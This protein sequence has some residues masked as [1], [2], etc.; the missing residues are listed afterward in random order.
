MTK[1]TNARQYLPKQR[2]LILITMWLFALMAIIFIDKP[3]SIYINQ[4]GWDKWL[5]LRNITEKLPAVMLIITILV[6]AYKNLGKNNRYL[7]AI[8]GGIYFYLMISLAEVIKNL[9]KITFGRYWPKTWFDSNF[10]LIEHGVYGFNW[11]NGFN[12]HSAFPSGHSTYI[13]F[14]CIWLILLLPK[15]NLLWLLLILI[16]P[17]CLIILNYHFL[18]DCLAGVG[19][20][21]I[22]GLI[23]YFWWQKIQLKFKFLS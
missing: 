2:M 16:M 21:Y 14:C 18:G 6:V 19:L 3:L 9:L 8:V 17:I 13:A 23:S 12:N 5:L 20:G 4:Q 1:Y 7:P 11:F 10:S 15:L 22:L